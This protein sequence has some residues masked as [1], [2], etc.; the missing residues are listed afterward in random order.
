MK[1]LGFAM[2]LLLGTSPVALEDNIGGDTT[3]LSEYAATP[4][5]YS[6]SLLMTRDVRDFGAK[7]DGKSDDT[8]AVQTGRKCRC[9]YWRKCYLCRKWWRNL[10]VV[11][12]GFLERP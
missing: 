9:G 12:H 10:Q 5:N 8:Q 2:L 4:E 11:Y 3:T 6:R 1:K 7:C